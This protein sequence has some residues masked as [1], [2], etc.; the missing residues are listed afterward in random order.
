MKA[1]IMG[2]GMIGKRLER[3]ARLIWPWRFPCLFKL[4]TGLNCPGCGGTRALIALLRGKLFL[5]FLYHPF[6]PY[7][8]LVA[9]L[10]LG[11]HA[12]SRMT[13]NKKYRLRFDERYTYVG[14]A[15]VAVNFLVK[16]LLLIGFRIDVLEMLPPV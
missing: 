14:I 2:Y 4:L 9:L 15:I 3:V 10:L 8:A 1:A 12:V 16:N 7:C 5:S 13:G 11:S 6:V